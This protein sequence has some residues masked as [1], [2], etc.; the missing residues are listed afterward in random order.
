MRKSAKSPVVAHA[1]SQR[2][3]GSRGGTL[4]GRRLCCASV[5]SRAHVQNAFETQ[6][7]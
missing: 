3:I 6:L 2:R 5:F 4:I 7:F 1:K